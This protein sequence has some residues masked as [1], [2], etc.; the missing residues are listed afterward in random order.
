MRCGAQWKFRD[1]FA[2]KGLQS[3]RIGGEGEF[4]VADGECGEGIKL[5][6][7][8]IMPADQSTPVNTAG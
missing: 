6:N 2:G 5:C 4:T 7:P 8:G 1:A 3:G